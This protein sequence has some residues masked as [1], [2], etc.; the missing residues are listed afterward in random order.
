MTKP[1]A[2]PVPC[3]QYYI[4]VAGIDAAAGR[5]TQGGGKILNGPHQVP[6]GSWIAQ[7]S[8]PQ[9]AMFAMVSA[10]R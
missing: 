3:W 8:D 7:C 1:P 5:V 9:G 6:G 10:T 2:V 4:N